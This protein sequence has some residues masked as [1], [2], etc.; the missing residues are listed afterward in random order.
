VEPTPA[1]LTSQLRRERRAAFLFAVA[2]VLLL[3]TV[4]TVGN[5]LPDALAAVFYLAFLGSIGGAQ[6]MTMTAV[7][8]GSRRGQ[9]DMCLGTGRWVLEHRDESVTP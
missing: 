6:R 9:V 8:T 2:G 7:R 1:E 3:A 5:Q 4:L